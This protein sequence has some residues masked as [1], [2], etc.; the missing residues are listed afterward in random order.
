MS[1]NPPRN[2]IYWFLKGRQPSS[3]LAA[4]RLVRFTRAKSANDGDAPD[5][6]WTIN[7]LIARADHALDSMTR[8]HDKSFGRDESGSVAIAHKDWA[9]MRAIG[10]YIPHESAYGNRFEV[11]LRHGIPESI[12]V[13][14]DRERDGVA[15]KKEDSK[16]LFFVARKVDG[17]PWSV[18][19][20]HEGT[21]YEF[22][23]IFDFGRGTIGVRFFLTLVEVKPG[24]GKVFPCRRLKTT[25]TEV[26]KRSKA[27]FISNRSWVDDGAGFG[28][29]D[30][31][32]PIE[33]YLCLAINFFQMM[34]YH[35]Y[36]RIFDGRGAVQM[37]ITVEE[38]KTLF[39]D[40]VTAKAKDGRRKRIIHW[41]KS[42]TRSTGSNVR[43]H[44]RGE[45]EFE[46]DGKSVI[47]QM[48]GKHV[49]ARYSMPHSVGYITTEPPWWA[50]ASG[51]L[52]D[53][54]LEHQPVPWE[55]EE[56]TGTNPLTGETFKYVPMRTHTLH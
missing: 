16:F 34:E 44:F 47:I 10:P 6:L 53:K 1:Q 8:G 29:E 13:G 32:A 5:S 46:I 21:H 45:R 2:T 4:S 15:L 3:D 55:K 43:T 35:W 33:E 25:Y 39:A 38:A 49:Q 54:W 19:P 41:V 18:Q 27:K 20:K 12:F 17:L 37:S 11:D 14:I 52:H 48:P 31:A 9:D 36:A 30:G 26:G 7:D 50:K 23:P 40:R 51:Y 28:A 24:I 42:H 22:S 56:V